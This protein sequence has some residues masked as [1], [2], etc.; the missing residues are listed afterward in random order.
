M[1]DCLMMMIFSH[2]ISSSVDDTVERD[3]CRNIGGRDAYTCAV[4]K[5]ECK[6]PRNEDD[7]FRNICHIGSSRCS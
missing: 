2:M 1:P 7:S 4:K 5:V 3:E 6:Q